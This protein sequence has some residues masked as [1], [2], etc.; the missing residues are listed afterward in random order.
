MKQ[1]VPKDL[2]RLVMRKLHHECAAPSRHGARNAPTERPTLARRAAYFTDFELQKLRTSIIV[3]TN[4]PS[5]NG[6][7]WSQDDE[8]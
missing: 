3:A 8:R 4:L 7:A 6:P 2:R 1:Q 5:G